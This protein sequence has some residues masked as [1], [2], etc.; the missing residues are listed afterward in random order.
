MLSKLGILFIIGTLFTS[1]SII[2]FTFKELKVI[3]NLIPSKIYKFS[4][5][6][7]FFSI[8][9]FFVLLLA[10]ILSDFSLVNVYENSHSNKPLFYKISGTWGNHEGSLLLWINILVL[11]SFLFL[12]LTKNSDKSFKILTLLFQNLLIITFLIF[13]LTNSNPFSELFPVPLEGLGLNPILQ[14]PALAIHP[15]L[16]YIGFVGSSIYFSA[17]LAALI[18]KID[19]QSFAIS[20]KSWVL[21]SWFFQTV[22]ILVGSIWAYYELGWGGYWFWDPVENSS[23]MPWFVMTALLHSIL[24]LERRIGLYSWVIVLSILTFTMSVT[25]TFLVRSGILNS[26]HTFASDPSRGLFILSFLVIM[27]FSSIFIF[28]KFS[29]KENKK[30]SVFSKEAFIIANNWFMIFFLGV[31]LIGT[32]YPVLLDTIT[33][34][35]ISVGPPYYNLI[36]APFL[37]PLLFLMTS[38]PN[39]KWISNEVRSLFNLVLVLSV[40]FFLITFFLI[41]ENNLLINLILFFSIY[42]ITQTL[43]DFYES[44]KKKNINISR[45][46]SHLG[47]GLLIFFIYINHIF[48]VENN[49]NLKLGETK[50]TDYYT[51]KFV[52]LEEQSIKNYKSIIGYFNVSNKKNF[53]SKELRPEIRVYDKPFT[54]TYEASINSNLFSDTYLTMSNISDT[55]VF[56]IKFQVKPFMNLIWLSVL[57]LSLG[58][59]LN[60]FKRKKYEKN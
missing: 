46:I 5:F 40:T 24:V 21:V 19:S 30:Y 53:T 25:G 50:K 34:S 35:K 49:F 9:S 15:P 16:L 37:I 10:Y 27:V 55:D 32:L 2:F 6:Q 13:L 12:F 47:F 39:Y 41:K 22:G 57:L 48:S 26:V 59:V 3:D 33:G 45:I 7:L 38:G 4:L 54:I 56:N 11:F 43:F 14:D 20:I 23:L 18:S 17:A 44:F 28:F 51:I 52:N 8:S 60:F 1:L 58:G 29:P 31:V 42:L 36:L